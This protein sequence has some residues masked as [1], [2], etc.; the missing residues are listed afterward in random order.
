M[1]HLPQRM[2]S[3]TR[4]ESSESSRRRVAESPLSI[5]ALTSMLISF[6]TRLMNLI[7]LKSL[8]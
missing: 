5:A 3:L 2:S 1:R 8:S 7:A 4:A 6:G